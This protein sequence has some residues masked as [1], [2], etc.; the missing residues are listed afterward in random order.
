[1]DPLLITNVICD[2]EV[3]WIMTANGLHDKYFPLFCLCAEGLVWFKF[4]SSHLLPCLHISDV[5]WDRVVLV[6]A[7]MT[8]VPIDVGMFIND[9]M[10]R[11]TSHWSFGLKFPS[12][13]TT[14]FREADMVVEPDME[15]QL[16][17]EC[18]IP[19]HHQQSP[20]YCSF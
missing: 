10:L 14:L 3:E 7:I 4:V 1:M 15:I 6:Y 2:G 19:T 8:R 18:I 11:T 16:A 20:T 12:L 13:I 9:A 17:G 5:T